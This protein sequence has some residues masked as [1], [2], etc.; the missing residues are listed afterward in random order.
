MPYTPASIAAVWIAIFALLG[1]TASGAVSGPW[2]VL[3]VL[4]A[5]A[6]PSLLRRPHGMLARPGHPITPPSFVPLRK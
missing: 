4:G 3:V 2:L 5:L 1:I 6:A